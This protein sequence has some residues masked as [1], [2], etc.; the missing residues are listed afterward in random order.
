VVSGYNCVPVT[1]N[2]TAKTYT[3]NAPS[4]N[5]KTAASWLPVRTNPA[6]NDILVFDGSIQANASVS[7]DFTTAENLGKLRII[8]NANVTLTSAASRKVN[9]GTPSSI[10][11][12]FEISAGSTLNVN[13]SYPVLINLPADCFASV[14]GNIVFQ[15]AAHQFTAA[16]AGGITFNNGSSFTAGT[17]FSENAFGTTS[18]NSIVFASGST[19]IQE[20]GSSPFGAS[21]PNSVLVFQ[22]GS[23]FKLKT[24]SAPSLDGRTYANFEVDVAAFS[25]SFTG[26][27]GVTMDNLTLTNSTLV[28]MNLTGTMNIKGNITVNNGTL[29]FS[30]AS[31]TNVNLNGT[32]AQ[33]ISGNGTL[34]IE[35]NASFVVDNTVIADKNITF[36]GNLSINS[37]KSFTINAGKQITVGGILANTS[38]AGLIIKSDATGTG[39][40]ITGSTPNATVERY[41]TGASNAWHQISSPVAA[42]GIEPGFVP[43]LTSTGE[44]F[45]TWYETDGVWVNYK[46]TGTAPTWNTANGSTNFVP[47]KGYLV[48]YQASNPTKAFSGTLNSG[49][50]NFAMTTSGTTGFAKI[51]LAGNPY[52]S[53]IDWKSASGWIK[54]NIME[55]SGGGHTFYTWNESES[56]YG[57][58]NDASGSDIGTLGVTRQIAPMQGFIVTAASAGNLSMTD[59]V[60]VHSTQAWQ[61]SGN[62]GFRLKVNAPGKKGSDEISFELGHNSSIGGAAK[63]NSFVAEAPSL[64]TPKSG[65]EYS[66]SFLESLTNETVIPV[67]F[68]AGIDGQYSLAANLENL[69]KAQIYLVDI[70]L[71]K[72]QNLSDNPVY[73]FAASTTDEPNRFKLTFKTVGINETVFEHPFNIYAT[74]NTVYVSNTSATSI[75]GEVYVYNTLGQVK[76]HQN[77]NGDLTKLNLAAAAGYYLVKVFTKETTFTGKVFLKQ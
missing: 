16:D 63:W 49:T 44:D 47:G 15:N 25:Q 19:Y 33:T 55:E 29:S 62:E 56:N 42:Q 57:A 75:K 68:K 43:S 72:T 18:Y 51:N 52:P 17:G 31:L 37:G 12:H 70:K 14:S 77:L 38:D 45:F 30:P 50:I 32:S 74:D 76:A 59:A 7:L 61:K 11:P 58:Y 64:S 20:A 6:A 9:I 10:S 67:T 71:N 34:T 23:L 73:T 28:G 22:T 39:S 27:T 35:S 21:Q 8:N 1:Y 54:T 69:S 53:S 66:I 48:A 4:G 65:T 60:R 26:A 13:A 46:N 3:W 24:N 36:G 41:I 2:L 40:L 5:W